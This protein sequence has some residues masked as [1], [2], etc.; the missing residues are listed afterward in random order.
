MRD[1]RQVETIL[2]EFYSDKS[3]VKAGAPTLPFRPN[4]IYNDASGLGDSIILTGVIPWIKVS[5]PILTQLSPHRIDQTYLSDEPG[6]RISELAQH[7]WLGGHAIQ[8]FQRS[9]GLEVSL[10][11]SGKLKYEPTLTIPNRVFVHTQNGTDWK[12]SIPNSLAEEETR[13]V[14]EFFDKNDN[15]KPYFYNNELSL[16][17]LINEI[18]R[19]EYFLGIDSGPMHIAA[20]LDRKSIIIINDPGCFVYLPKIKECELPNLEW[21]YPQ[22]VHLNRAGETQLIPRLT[23]ET[24]TDAFIG[25]IYPYWSHEY[26]DII[27]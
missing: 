6:L 24:L 13:I 10:K 27:E 5:S 22:N 3:T 17:E 15:F 20:A 4:S 12:R 2:R 11:P 21:L 8:R 1:R 26:L 16:T 18:E 7:D 19:C 14:Q 9:L 23:L 25:K